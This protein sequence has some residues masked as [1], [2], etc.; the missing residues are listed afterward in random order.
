M[1]SMSGI[2]RSVAVVLALAGVAGCR[3]AESAAVAPAAVATVVRLAPVELVESSPPVRVP[4]VLSRKTEAELAFKVGGV[5][6][7]L[8]VRAGDRVER[9][10]RLARLQLDEIDAQVVQARSAAEKARRDL[11]RV[12]KL[13]EGRVATLENLQDARTAVELAEATVRIAEFN[14]QHAEIVAPSAGRVLRRQAEPGEL[15]GPGRAIVTF[16]S[17]EDGWLVRVGLAERD[18]TQ[19]ATDA[20]ARVRFDET[21]WAEARVTRISEANDAATRTT[22]VE[23]ALPTAPDG[24]RSGSI[25]A[26]EITRRSVAARPRVPLTALVEGG[27]EKAVLFLVAPGA[28]TARRVEVRVELIDGESAWLRT[29]LPADASVVASGAEYL[30]DG[31]AVTVAK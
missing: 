24:A 5:L 4:G 17:D 1:K 11:A 29:A 25:V 3:K 18:V 7:E 16:A 19:V 21:V 31:A 26:V 14:R 27:G 20:M 22:P 30:R 23:I 2:I 10:Q 28:T 9:G 12:E 8:P 15:V 6:A 13:R